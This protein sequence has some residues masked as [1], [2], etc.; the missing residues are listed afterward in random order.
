MEPNAFLKDL[1]KWI[2]LLPTKVLPVSLIDAAD[3]KPMHV[4]GFMAR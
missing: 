2:A 4:I 3:S 1:G